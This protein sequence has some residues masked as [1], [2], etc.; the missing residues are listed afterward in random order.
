MLPQSD[1]T[2][3][4]LSANVA[5][6]QAASKPWPMT[7]VGV[8]GG[9]TARVCHYKL[10]DAPGQKVITGCELATSGEFLVK[11]VTPTQ[12]SGGYELTVAASRKLK[13]TFSVPILP[14]SGRGACG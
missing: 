7:N 11:Q 1:G 9:S 13:G 2:L 5:L 14:R 10:G 6:H 4:Y 3:L 8:I 12:M